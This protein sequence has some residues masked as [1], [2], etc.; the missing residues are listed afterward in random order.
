MPIKRKRI[1]RLGELLRAARRALDL[2][3]SVLAGYV[4]VSA[5]TLS[6]WE[7]GA[8]SPTPQQ[9][10]RLVDAL[11]D[12]PPDVLA[13][14]ADLLGVELEEADEPQAVAPPVIAPA[15]AVPPPSF[16]DLRAA[17]DGVVLAAADEHDVVPRKLRAFAVALLERIQALGVAPGEAAKHITA[18]EP[19]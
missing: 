10:V 8:L 7:N 16:V 13:S 5:R 2:E 9:R 11:Q 17:L 1:S 4:S 19:R 14:L 6:R 15:P 3:Q 12:A 18:K